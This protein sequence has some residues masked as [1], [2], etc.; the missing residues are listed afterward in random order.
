MHGDSITWRG[1]ASEDVAVEL[2]R[3]STAIANGDGR[4]SQSGAIAIRLASETVGEP[5]AIRPGD[6]LRVTAG[7]RPPETVDIPQ[8]QAAV[9]ETGA[10]II[11]TAPV[12]AVVTLKRIIDGAWFRTDPLDEIAVGENG[13]GEVKLTQAKRDL[14]G[15]A[16]IVMEAGHTIRFAF[17]SPRVYVDVSS[18]GISGQ[19]TYGTQVELAL[20]NALGQEKS[21]AEFVPQKRQSLEWATTLQDG[22]ALGVGTRITATHTASDG[23]RV[24]SPSEVPKMNITVDARTGALEG[25]GPPSTQLQIA[26][27]DSDGIAISRTVQTDTEGRYRIVL[28]E[29]DAGRGVAAD[30]TYDSGGVFVYRA[31]HIIDSTTIGLYT[32]DVSGF[33]GLA[34]ITIRV[35]VQSPGGDMKAQGVVQA[36]EH[37]R[38][39]FSMSVSSDPRVSEDLLI[40][41][42]DIVII[43]WAKGDP[44]YITVPTV[45]VDVDVD[46][47][48]I[49]GLAPPAS[50]VWAG[51]GESDEIETTHSVT[52]DT[53]GR[54]ELVFGN[55]DLQRPATGIVEVRT[56]DRVRFTMGWAAPAVTVELHTGEVRGLGPRG[57]QMSARVVDPEGKGVGGSKFFLRAKNNEPIGLWTTRLRDWAGEI[58]RPEP[59]DVLDLD[60]SSERIAV[61]IPWLHSDVDV[62]TDVVRG[63]LDP[64]S[65]ASLTL[66]RKDG[67]GQYVRHSTVMVQGDARGEFEY[68]F[69]GV[70]DI[71]FNDEIVMDYDTPD[72][73]RVLSVSSV[74]G[75]VIDLDRSAVHG[76]SEPGAKIYVDRDEDSWNGIASPSGSFYIH[77]GAGKEQAVLGAGD[78]VIVRRETPGSSSGN[79]TVASL[80]VPE[81]SF[82]VD[83]DGGHVRG[84][85]PY[86]GEV[87]VDVASVFPRT[88]LGATSAYGYGRVSVQESGL[89]EAPLSKLGL[90]GLPVIT[91]PGQ[92]YRAI[93]KMRNGIQL[94]RWEVT[95]IANFQQGGAR[96]CGYGQP[97][98]QVRATVISGQAEGAVGTARVGSNL[99][100]EVE[101]KHPSEMPVTL[102]GG[103]QLE[104]AFGEV[105]DQVTLPR[106]DLEADWSHQSAQ[107]A[108]P[109]TRLTGW[110][111]IGTQL[112]MRIP[113][114]GCLRGNSSA[115]TLDFNRSEWF[116][117]DVAP[118]VHRGE[119]VLVGHYFGN[120]A[121]R[122]FHLKVRP[123]LRVFLDTDRIEGSA[124]P[125]L[126]ARWRLVDSRGREVGTAETT[127]DTYGRIAARM[128]ATAG[129]GGIIFT[130]GMK[131]HM[132]IGS[133]TEQIG[134]KEVTFDYSP[135]S[136]VDVV[137]EPKQRV[138][139]EFDT[140]DGRLH[141]VAGVTD[142]AGRFS[143]G[144]DDLPSRSGWEFDDVATLR[145]VVIDATGH[146]FI[147]ESVLREPEQET[148]LYLPLCLYR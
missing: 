134:V 40:L 77:L 44:R 62:D 138:R 48:R 54:F 116:D 66:R 24:V 19:A 38:Y 68:D 146:E 140:L 2:I 117:Y 37:G 22:F 15:L 14:Q 12:G 84:Q 103:S 80:T 53:A 75:V 35:K 74:P 18:G 95:P 143:V 129:D 106:F 8:L 51:L 110:V 71:H 128:E 135:A 125:S 57:Q 104:M 78:R 101:L 9:A 72:G 139:V 137:A 76:Y 49:A 109:T 32:A 107:R 145:A 118:Q 113:A 55:V 108:V 3:N 29:F 41:P 105:V 43:D 136:G 39:R 97:G 28:P 25:E 147:S 69:S 100:Y 67:T 87:E 52:V 114:T 23:A 130:P 120:L 126:Q 115:Y 85:A 16:E 6:T 4:T 148:S 42:G 144:G 33:I 83:A 93:V 21:I 124:S 58:V 47:D 79:G 46:T 61:Q 88:N 90:W 133:T 102:D 132:E 34:G 86:P 99:A 63:R 123:K 60:V 30:I 7:D 1:E 20:S 26:L 82:E 141:Q 73:H 36:N 64:M 70:Y 142:A 119:G 121:Y 89:Y 94:V 27:R 96:V 11:V 56:D 122:Q 131:L 59:G 98:T 5:V 31:S 65:T 91:L 111:G 127:G 45:Q 50:M 13:K 92:R 10:M 112:Y 81:F 17:A